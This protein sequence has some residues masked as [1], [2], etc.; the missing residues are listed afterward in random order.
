MHGERV[1][2]VS[3]A[4]VGVLTVWFGVAAGCLSSWLVVAF[5]RFIDD[6]FHISRELIVII[7]LGLVQSGTSTSTRATHSLG[8]PA[9][10]VGKATKK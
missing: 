6:L 5:C 1:R 4:P 8:C 7:V 3:L 2:S 9:E 10:V